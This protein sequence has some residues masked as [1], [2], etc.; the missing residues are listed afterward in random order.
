MQ[1]LLFFFVVRLLCRILVVISSIS[2]TLQGELSQSGYEHH[3]LHVS[4][5]F[6]VP[7]AWAAWATGMTHHVW[8]RLA[9]VV[10]MVASDSNSCQE[11]SNR[12]IPQ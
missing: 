10:M 2:L 3:I 1:R 6:I 5:R 4:T 8:Q 11:S 12:T 7:G 9:Q